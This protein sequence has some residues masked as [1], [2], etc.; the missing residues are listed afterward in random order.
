MEKR[1]LRA[2][3]ILI[4]AITAV[5][6]A[7][8]ALFLA[9]GEPGATVV[10]TVDGVEIGRYPLATPREVAIPSE[11]GGY[12]LLIIRDGEAFIREASCPD[13]LCADHRPIS[14]V[15]ESILCLPNKVA[16]RVE[17]ETDDEVDVIA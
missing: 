14:R 5:A 13:G 8:L 12:N 3:L 4:A 17:G 11:G 15:G 6:L 7:S 10:V 2:D 1:K 9:L 16:V